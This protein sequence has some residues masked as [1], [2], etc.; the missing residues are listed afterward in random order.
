[1]NS[2]QRGP[3]ASL[4]RLRAEVRQLQQANVRLESDVRSAQRELET[5]RSGVGWRVLER[6][7]RLRLRALPAGQPPRPRLSESARWRHRLP[8]SWRVPDDSYAGAAASTSAS[9]A[10]SG[11]FGRTAA[12]PPVSTVARPASAHRHSRGRHPRR[13]RGVRIQP[14][15]Q[16]PDAGVQHRGGVAERRRRVGAPAAL[17]TVGALH[18]RRCVDGGTTFG[19]FCRP[20]PPQT[21]ASRWRC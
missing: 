9:R 15:R 18:R 3:D 19:R 12:E 1:M 10:A 20:L 16:H 2:D 11:S 13:H 8:S 14:S 21:A 17:S 5:I 7:R 6:F 4:H